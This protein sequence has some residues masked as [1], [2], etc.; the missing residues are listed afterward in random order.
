[1]GNTE[2]SWS[3]DMSD[4]EK[5]LYMAELRVKQLAAHIT[6]GAT[7]V[8]DVL[9]PSHNY[10]PF[11]SYQAAM[12]QFVTIYTPGHISIMLRTRIGTGV[13]VYS[14]DIE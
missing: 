3:D 12:E 9:T 11:D 13:E 7:D 1:M 2:L 5:R 8:Y 10:G 14:K 6:S 4:L